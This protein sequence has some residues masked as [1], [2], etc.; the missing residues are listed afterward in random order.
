MVSS[1]WTPEASLLKHMSIT[2]YNVEQEANYRTEQRVLKCFLFDFH[3]C[4][5]CF[6]DVDG[7]NLG[8]KVSIPRD[9]MIE[10]LSHFGNRGAR[11]FK[12]RQRRSDK[13][14]FENFQYESKAQINVG[15][16]EP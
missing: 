11:L 16:T 3:E 9:I 8:K 14:T 7:M 13:Y 1:G 15:T 5:Y 10:E 12:M 4:K 2:Y 6:P